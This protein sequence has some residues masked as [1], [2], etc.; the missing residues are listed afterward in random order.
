M[1]GLTWISTGVMGNLA[2]DV[3]RPKQNSIR[4]P[5]IPGRLA[6][7]RFVSILGGTW[8]E[9]ILGGGCVEYSVLEGGQ[10]ANNHNLLCSV[11]VYYVDGSKEGTE[12]DPEI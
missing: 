12:L 9:R 6:L 8:I 2:G 4:L 5:V 10:V 7:S 3:D 1:V 11:I